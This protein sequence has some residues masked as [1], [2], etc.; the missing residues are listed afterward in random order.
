MKSVDHFFNKV[1]MK[2]I[3]KQDIRDFCRDNNLAMPR[4]SGKE[5]RVYFDPSYNKTQEQHFIEMARNMGY[6]YQL[7]FKKL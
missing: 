3:T 1:N 7:G 6:G 5:K 2:T 4:F